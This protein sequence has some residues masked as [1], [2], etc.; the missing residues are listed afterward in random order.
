MVLRCFFDL[1]RYEAWDQTILSIKIVSKFDY[2]L[3]SFD[4]E[5]KKNY[6]PL[7][8]LKLGALKRLGKSKTTPKGRYIR[9]YYSPRKIKTTFQKLWCLRGFTCVVNHPVHTHTYQQ[10]INILRLT[11]HGQTFNKHKS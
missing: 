5:I 3:N 7:E 10:W 1:C 6:I 9:H 4:F 11:K 8:I 2:T